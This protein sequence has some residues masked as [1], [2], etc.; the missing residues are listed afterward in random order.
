[1]PVIT[2]VNPREIHDSVKEAVVDSLLNN[3]TA[4]L[5]GHGIRGKILY[6]SK[7]RNILVT[8]FLLPKPERERIEDEEAS[9]IH[10]S[11]HG[12]DFQIGSDNQ[13]IK[14]SVKPTISVY[15]RILP[16]PDE[17]KPGAICRPHF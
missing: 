15:V 11:A 13:N 6:N 3:L 5:A 8:E 7:P 2:A 17:V 16:T 1:M 12:L 4:R 10:I 14:I 9:P